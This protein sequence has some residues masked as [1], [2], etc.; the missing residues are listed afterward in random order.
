[1]NKKILKNVFLMGSSNL[2][3]GAWGRRY[4]FHEP[5]LKLPNF[6]IFDFYTNE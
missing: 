1:M 6:D 4:L 2:T 3:P 5:D